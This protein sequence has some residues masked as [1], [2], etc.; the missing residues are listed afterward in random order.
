MKKTVCTYWLLLMLCVP[1]LGHA[2]ISDQSDAVFSIV[3]P[4]A[5]AQAV[6]MG[7]LPV[8]GL[9]DSLIQPFVL[10]IGRARIA[11]DTFRITGSDAASFD[12]IAG[13]GPMH[14]PVGDGHAVGFSFHPTSA[15]VK[16]ATIVMETQIDTQYYAIS[17]EAVERQI[18]LAAGM[19]DFGAISIG[20]H[21]DSTLVLIRNLSAGPVTVTGAEQ[22]GPDLQQFSIIS[23]HAPFWLPPF[24]SHEMTLRYEAQKGGR[25][26]G[27][28]LFSIEGSVDLLT[29]RLFG[30]GLVRDAFATLA[31]DT[32]VAAPGEIVSVPIRLRDAE[33]V[34]FTGASA[35]T[36]ELRYHAALL[37]PFGATPKGRIEGNERVIPLDGLPVIPDQDGVLARFDFIAV[38][39]D[40]ETTPLM[41]QNSAARGAGF[42]VLESP[43]LFHLKD[44]CREGGDRYF[45]AAGSL[46]LSQNQPNPFN[47]ST[48][49][50]FETIEKGPVRLYVLDPL[51]RYVRTLVDEPLQP[52]RYT[53]V[54]ELGDV[55]SGNYICVLR[56]ATATRMI[57]MQLLK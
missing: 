14:V 49:I 26:S 18:E 42:A 31:T 39:G 44:I 30:E 40:V 24:G 23:G 43:G 27:S 22:R 2:Q 28:I 37:V 11:I 38:L 4:S 51:G 3:V 47:S 7:L 25:S 32:L 5:E 6:D 41:L 50:A 56:T 1:A 15:G 55:P 46:R 36:T 54:L 10:N 21:R 8:G 9:R 12:V 17:G 45:N 19:L 35:F 20:A 53:R 16:T 13:Q 52:G 33:N 34:M 57:R 48:L 29:A